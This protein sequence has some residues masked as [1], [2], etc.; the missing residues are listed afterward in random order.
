MA[1]VQLFPGYTDKELSRFVEEP[2]PGVALLRDWRES[3]GATR[4]CVDVLVSCLQQMGRQDVAKFIQDELGNVERTCF[5]IITYTYF[6][7]FL[8]FLIIVIF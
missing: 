3:N 8:V 7:Y 6:W 5:L 4:Y 1:Y 2:N